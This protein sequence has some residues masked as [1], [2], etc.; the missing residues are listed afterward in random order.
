MKIKNEEFNR[1][2]MA[3]YLLSFCKDEDIQ[4]EA[5]RLAGLTDA[6]IE[7]EFFDLY[8]EMQG[9]VPPP[10]GDYDHGYDL[11]HIPGIQ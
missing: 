5:E 11:Q 4:A 7:K 2:G 1:D 3:N 10:D 6:E 9:M 8:T